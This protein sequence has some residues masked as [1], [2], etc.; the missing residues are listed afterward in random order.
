MLSPPPLTALLP[1]QETCLVCSSLNPVTEDETE[2]HR[3]VTII[4]KESRA[5]NILSN[6]CFQHSEPLEDVKG[7]NNNPNNDV[8]MMLRLEGM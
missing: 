7:Q 1:A 5:P 2:A 4:H 8:D 3:V 6:F